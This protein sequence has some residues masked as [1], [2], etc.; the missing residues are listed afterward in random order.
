MPTKPRF[1]GGFPPKT[2]LGVKEQTRH[3]A[4]LGSF[5]AR[6]KLKRTGWVDEQYLPCMVRLASWCGTGAC[7]LVRL[8]G[9]L[10]APHRKGSM[11]NGAESARLLPSPWR[12]ILWQSTPGQIVGRGDRHCIPPTLNLFLPQR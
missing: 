3:S 5:F 8:E 1:L 2:P 7:S 4:A 12:W 10:S 11:N 9:L 6:A